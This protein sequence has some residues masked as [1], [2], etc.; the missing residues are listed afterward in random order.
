MLRAKRRIPYESHEAVG[1]L[2]F[3]QDDDAVQDAY[4]N[5]IGLGCILSLTHP[6]CHPP[7]AR[8]P[9]A[10]SSPPRSLSPRFSLCLQPQ[11]GLRSPR[12]RKSEI[13]RWAGNEV[14]GTSAGLSAGVTGQGGVRGSMGPRTRERVEMRRILS[15]AAFGRGVER[16][17][18]QLAPRLSAACND[19]SR[20]VKG[21]RGGRGACGCGRLRRPCWP[22]RWLG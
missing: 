20:G 17:T 15:R 14:A 8:P 2:R 7:C 12:T 9:R 3:A 22:R 10:A 1:I 5:R 18:S 21:R 6:A 4:V 16:K 19:P 11:T 13:E